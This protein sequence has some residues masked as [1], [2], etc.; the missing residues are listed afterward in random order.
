MLSYFEVK[1]LKKKYVFD[2]N[3]VYIELELHIISI[4]INKNI[5]DICLFFE[6]FATYNTVRFLNYLNFTYHII[7]RY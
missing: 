7:I 5:F 6:T 2:L 3:N 4:L 1:L